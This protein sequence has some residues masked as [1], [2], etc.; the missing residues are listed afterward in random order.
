MSTSG[1][2]G[3]RLGIVGATGVVGSQLLELIDERAV[4]CAELRLYSSEEHGGESIES[5]GAVRR[6]DVLSDP[7]ELSDLD[8]VFLA[9][10][11][12][13][14]ESIASQVSG[15]IIVD[16][17][18]ASLAPAGAPFVAPGFTTREQVRD[19]SRFKLFHTP[20]PAALALAT[21]INALGDTPF[22]AATLMLGAS[23]SGH[24]AISHLVE[25]SADLLNGKLD[26][27]E[28]ERQA[29]FNVALIG[30]TRCNAS[31]FP[32]FMARRCA[33]ACPTMRA[34]RIGLR[35]CARLPVFS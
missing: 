35:R 15:P 21:I 19:L 26:L 11:R 3:L 8:V 6:I 2:A 34:V 12:A 32:S 5:S 14:A 16:L 33:W 18:A 27:E 10:H 22:Y 9:V 4:A 29:A 23:S 24:G 1:N 31:R 13:D 28:D 30:G 7:S 25:E 20:H 17:S